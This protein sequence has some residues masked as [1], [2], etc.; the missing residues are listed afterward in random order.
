MSYLIRSIEL[1]AEALGE[2]DCCPQT[3][4]CIWDEE[5]GC[6]K[7]WLEALKGNIKDYETKI[8]QLNKDTAEEGKV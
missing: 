2:S 5:N 1:I 3:I 4:G 6:T 8:L 7:C